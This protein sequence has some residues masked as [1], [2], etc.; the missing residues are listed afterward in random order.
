[1]HVRNNK[2]AREL[3]ARIRY[4]MEELGITQADLSDRCDLPLS[5]I[6]IYCNGKCIPKADAVVALAAG[7]SMTTDDLINFKI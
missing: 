7:L 1:M 5:N 3:A 4:R 6:S 2:Y